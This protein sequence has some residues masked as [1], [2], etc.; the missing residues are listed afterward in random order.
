MA[1]I[2]PAEAQQETAGGPANLCQELLAFMKAP[3]PEA[4][5][6]TAAANPAPAPAQSSAQQAASSQ[7]TAPPQQQAA[8]AGKGSSALA[9]TTAAGAGASAKPEIGSDSAQAVTGQTGVA[10][11][12]P[13]PSKAKVAAGSV[14]N[15]PQKDSLSAPVPPADVTSTPKESIITVEQAE[16]LAAANDISQCQNAARKMRVAGVAMPP[17]LI[18]LAALDSQYQQ[19]G[20]TETAPFGAEPAAVDRTPPSQPPAPQ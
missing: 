12:A 5:T 7:Q 4:A 19:R 20:G 8:P 9:G 15:A 14:E 6:Q 18:A 13:D 17:P 11:D 3:P 10:T 1:P 16:E 2:D